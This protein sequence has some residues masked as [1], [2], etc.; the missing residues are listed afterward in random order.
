MR[1]F[2]R[3][4]DELNASTATSAKLLAL[5]RYFAHAPTEDAAWALY[6]L[7]GGKP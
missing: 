7:A 3:L 5:R 4:Y 2:A 6:F 1:G